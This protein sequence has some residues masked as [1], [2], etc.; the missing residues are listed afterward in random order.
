MKKILSH[1]ML[2]AAIAI[3]SA[4]AMAQN[5]F[6]YQAVIRN[7]GE[8]VSNQDVSLLISI[9][10]GSDVCYQ[11]IQKVKTNAYGNISV[12]VGEGEPKTGS[13][14]TIPWETMQ[15]MMQVEVSTDGSE[16]YVNL[17]Q[18]Q[19]QPVP[20]AIYAAS[21]ATVIQPAAAS[22]DPIFEVR[23]NNG[24]LMFAVYENGVK[25]Y[26]D[27]DGTKAAKSK[28]AVAGRSASKGEENLLTINSEGT[29]VYV[30]ENANK[31]AKS[32]FAVAGRSAGKTDTDLLTIDNS[33]STIYVDGDGKAAKSRF[34]VAGRSGKSKKSN[35]NYSI[36]N[37]NSTLYVDFNDNAAGKGAQADVLTI[38]GGQATFYID[39]TEDGKAAKSKFAVAG[40]SADKSVQTAFVIDGTGT[41][42][43]IDD[44]GQ[45]GKAAKSKFA[46]AGRSSGKGDSKFFSITPDST[47]IY[48][49]DEVD[50]TN[51][52]SLA[53]SFAIVGMTQNTDL[54]FINKD[55]TVIK[56]NTYV[57]EEMQSATG[58]VNKLDVVYGV[59]SGS[60]KYKYHRA[61]IEEQ[62]SDTIIDYC[63]T[64]FGRDNFEGF[65]VDDFAEGRGKYKYIYNA[66]TSNSLSIDN[67]SGVWTWES[68][69]WYPISAEIMTCPMFSLEGVNTEI[70]WPITEYSSIA[71]IHGGDINI[72]DIV[73][74]GTEK[75][76]IGNTSNQVDVD[77][78]S[79]NDKDDNTTCTFYVYNGIVL[80]I[81][82]KSNNDAALVI[83]EC[84]EFNRDNIETS[85]AHWLKKGGVTNFSGIASRYIGE[86][87][88]G[89]HYFVD[90]K[91]PSGNLWA[92]C[93]VGAPTSFDLGSYLAWGELEEKASYEEA[94]Y[95][96]TELNSDNDAAYQ[97]GI[98]K[99]SSD[100]CMPN[101]A[102]WQELIN[103]C[104][105]IWVKDEK[106]V[107]VTYDESLHEYKG[108][109]LVINSVDELYWGYHIELMNYIFL[110]TNGFYEQ[111]IINNANQGYYW[112]SDKQDYGVNCL[113]FGESY[114]QIG[115]NP[116][117][118]GL[119][120]RPVAY[121]DKYY[122]VD[123][124]NAS[125]THEGSF[126]SLD[127]AL[128]AITNDFEQKGDTLMTYTI[129]VNGE[130]GPA[131]ISV[132]ERIK[133]ITLCGANGLLNGEPQDAIVGTVSTRPLTVNSGNIIIKNLKLTGGGI[134]PENLD[135]S[136]QIIAGGGL[137]ISYNG[138]VTLDSGAF[139]MKNAA[140]TTEVSYGGGVY[141][142]RG[143]ELIMLGGSKISENRVG[144][145]G[146]Y[147]C[148]AGVYVNG[149][150][151]GGKLTMY[152][153]EIS[154]NKGV[155]S[156]SNNKT[157]TIEYSQGGG[158]YIDGFC[159]FYMYGGLI[160]KNIIEEGTSAAEGQTVIH[161]TGG[162]VCHDAGF[163]NYYMSGGM[164]TN[165]TAVNAPGLYVFFGFVGS[166]D[167][168]PINIGGSSYIND[169]HFDFEN[170]DSEVN[171]IVLREALTTEKNMS[172]TVENVGSDVD[173]NIL[174][175]FTEEGNYN[176]QIL[177]D[178][179]NR[180]TLTNENYSI[181]DEIERSSWHDDFQYSV[182]L[183]PLSK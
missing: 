106:G 121:K 131:E 180:I 33:G 127:E 122:W 183:V 58:E 114:Q 55:S 164:I 19:I 54:L 182:K 104:V 94:G 149:S 2:I 169:I 178:A 50:N 90:L 115:N 150:D 18:M 63:F 12:S 27:Q 60:L 96:V 171:G 154:E 64:N 74:T 92:S 20:Y 137:Y 165:N 78:Y 172:L 44:N 48:V 37:D 32:K 84:I 148:G 176:G 112:S 156:F 52:G 141:V 107:Y 14:A 26:V 174:S 65:V 87:Y 143:G 95:S 35:N 76:S 113:S 22:E 43:Y 142:F 98:V 91:L 117:Y 25:V 129:M 123:G 118:R 175:F 68:N 161:G 167:F 10:N 41:L 136:S 125:G 40:R 11:E 83:L 1:I 70:W 86:E 81:S 170:T 72:E 85:F 120:V 158:V 108:E 138:K 42:I 163:S 126:A 30:D 159:E 166:D 59:W 111:D 15:V 134:N 173:I 99:E 116:G 23:D 28:F 4:S 146:Y 6:S 21:T 100:W 88:S 181:S 144:G 162:G 56:A 9:L 93:N 75:Y 155:G 71:N 67:T 110:P 61:D 103:E 29:T 62:Q 79:Y 177:R 152:G 57:A 151:Y 160:T 145:D 147:G 80:Y 89:G 128:S 168:M 101:N 5:S 3:F 69:Q 132:P 51:N 13:F 119:Q 45:S 46:V 38:D 47:R 130:V 133:Q 66:S 139:V 73:K 36:D 17:G 157:N 39:E 135:E 97:W 53:A 179:I 102:D 140:C 77:V 24:E 109:N 153:G 124:N 82:K 31:A 8:V 7:N 49:N 34:A 105:W 16:N